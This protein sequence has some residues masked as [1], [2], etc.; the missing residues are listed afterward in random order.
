MAIGDFAI[1][2]PLPNI[3]LETLTLEALRYRLMQ[4]VA[5]PRVSAAGWRVSSRE[6][7]R[8]VAEGWAHQ[9]EATLY[10]RRVMEESGETI[11]VETVA[12]EAAYVPE[13]FLDDCK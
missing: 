6:R 11:K 1:D 9:L 10:G 12:T 8:H 13:T 3:R 4:V 7:L 5:E 2:D